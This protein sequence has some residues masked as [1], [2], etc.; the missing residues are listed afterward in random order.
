MIGLLFFLLPTTQFHEVA[1]NAPGGG[2]QVCGENQHGE[3]RAASIF[4]KIEEASCSG[5]HKQ[6]SCGL[7]LLLFVKLLEQQSG[8][9]I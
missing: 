2:A 3:A 6:A 5:H 9:L 1:P 4:K 8:Y 7:W